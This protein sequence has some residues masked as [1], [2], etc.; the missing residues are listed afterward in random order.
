L[1]GGHGETLRALEAYFDEQGGYSPWD[2]A[3]NPLREALGGF[4]ADARARVPA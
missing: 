1:Y 3:G 2:E 4:L